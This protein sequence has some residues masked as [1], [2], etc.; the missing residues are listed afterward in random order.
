MDVHAP[1]RTDMTTVQSKVSPSF[2]STLPKTRIK[3]NGPGFSQK[4]KKIIQDKYNKTSN[5]QQYP[6]FFAS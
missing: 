5:P 2:P 1:W 3:P 4:K 6:L